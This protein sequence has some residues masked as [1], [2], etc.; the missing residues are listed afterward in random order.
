[1]L[2]LL[3]AVISRRG[4]SSIGSYV[5]DPPPAPRSPR[6]WTRSASLSRRPTGTEHPSQQAACL[7]AETTVASAGC[8]EDNGWAWPV[9]A[10]VT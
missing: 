4:I 7:H 3:G 10:T 9:C 1:M 8:Q 6:T 5:I 2:L